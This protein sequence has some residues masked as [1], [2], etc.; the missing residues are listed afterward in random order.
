M[1]EESIDLIKPL[2][3]GPTTF[4]NSLTGL[5]VSPYN[6]ARFDG[7]PIKPSLGPRHACQPPS[8]PQGVF[9][10]DTHSLEWV[11][12]K[13]EALYTSRHLATHVAYIEQGVRKTTFPRQVV[14]V[15]VMKTSAEVVVV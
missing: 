6:F 8:T 15:D 9:S 14:L 2:D 7:S 4:M 12:C 5:G 10:S 13:G 3:F 1:H 11:H